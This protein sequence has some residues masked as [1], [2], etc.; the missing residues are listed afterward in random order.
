MTD[1]IDADDKQLLKA[2]YLWKKDHRKLA[3]LM[4]NYK[5]LLYNGDYDVITGSAAVEE[6]IRSTRW[7]LQKKYNSSRRLVWREGG[8]GSRVLGFYTRVGKFCRVV[9][10]GAG[11]QVPYDQPEAALNM[12]KDFVFRGCVEGR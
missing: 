3:V 7:K 8:Q 9:V 11:H 2:V 5:V 10:H 12:M 1:L 4:N 6:G